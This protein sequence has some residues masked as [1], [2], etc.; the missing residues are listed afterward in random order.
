MMVLVSRNLK[1][2]FRN[3]SG[4]YA[5]LIGASITF[6]VY[7]F[8][9]Q[10]QLVSQ[11][12]VFN[13][14]QQL[15]DF[16][17]IGGILSITAIT[18]TFSALGQRVDDIERGLHNDWQMTRVS[19]IQQTAAYFISTFL[20]SIFLQVAMTLLMVI[21]FSWQDNLKIDF[22]NGISL[23][24]ITIINTICAA[25]T[26]QLI[27]HFIHNR[28][29]FSRWSA[30]IGTTSGFLVATYMPLGALPK[31]AQYVVKVTPEA[32]AAASYRQLLMKKLLSGNSDSKTLDHLNQ[33]LGLKIKFVNHL[34]SSNDDLI[35]LL[36]I[37]VVMLFLIVFAEKNR[38]WKK[39]S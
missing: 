22:Q 35:L 20:I 11:W 32:Y 26:N 38:T 1:L 6:M 30:I 13:H 19:H 24:V 17:V 27:V 16:W 36:G 5:S 18:T 4:V 14:A 31:F 25:L 29:T 33:Y 7:I 3:R 10:Q 37:S 9:L 12:Q 8:F 23:V 28:D 34:F 39:G 15:L 2:Y 21:Y